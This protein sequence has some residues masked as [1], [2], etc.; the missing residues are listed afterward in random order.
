MMTTGQTEA[1]LLQFTKNAV[2]K[3]CTDAFEKQ[4]TSL[5][6]EPFSEGLKTQIRA[7][8]SQ[9][10]SV[11]EGAGLQLDSNS[12]EI[13]RNVGLLFFRI[14]RNEYIV[15]AD[16]GLIRDD[17]SAPLLES[18]DQTIESLKAQ[19]EDESAYDDFRFIEKFL[20]TES[21][22]SCLTC[23]VNNTIGLCKGAIFVSTS[24]LTVYTI[25]EFERR[26][27]QGLLSFIIAHRRAEQK[28]TELLGNAGTAGGATDLLMQ[29]ASKVVSFSQSSAQKA[30]DHLVSS[31]GDLD[32]KKAEQVSKMLFE[33]NRLIIAR[34]QD[35]GVLDATQ[36]HNLL[37]DLDH[38][39]DHLEKKLE[40]NAE[41]ADES[42]AGKAE[43]EMA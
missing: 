16:E 5:Y 18:A 13:L 35:S 17:V 32:D 4:S 9:L 7:N 26:Y 24:D 31:K 10:G 25:P 14:L 42:A 1:V 30:Q 21:Q 34:F 6:P 2:R 15:Q 41:K 12:G 33:E 11:E 29:E 43:T 40:S 23:L 19:V 38:D 3:S 8:V 37:H 22:S 27:D 39:M 20:G 36:A 28:L